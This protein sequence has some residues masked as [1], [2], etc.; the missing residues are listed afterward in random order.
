MCSSSCVRLNSQKLQS[1][2]IKGIYHVKFSFYKHIRRPS[3]KK[4]LLIGDY[5]NNCSFSC[6]FQSK[7]KGQCGLIGYL[8]CLLY[9]SF[10][11]IH[12]WSISPNLYQKHS[13]P[14]KLPRTILK[15]MFMISIHIINICLTNV[16]STASIINTY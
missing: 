13:S 16:H 15:I 3:S 6:L 5:G 11:F 14:Q 8:G 1:L 9:Q 12:F 7:Q 10:L 2:F 4:Y